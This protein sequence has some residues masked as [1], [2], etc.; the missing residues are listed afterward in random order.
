MDDKPTFR[1]FVFSTILLFF[2]GWGGLALLLNYSVPEVWPRWG[3]FALLI[4]AG[5][6]TNLPI[7]YLINTVLPSTPPAEPYVIVRQS[8]FVGVYLALLAWLSI[9]RVLNLPMIVWLGLGLAAI[10]YLLRLR[11][12]SSKPEN[13]TSRSSGS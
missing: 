11:E 3:F 13:V 4:L 1:P 9:G 10:E 2:G 7:S 12:T 8:V 5:T 6:G